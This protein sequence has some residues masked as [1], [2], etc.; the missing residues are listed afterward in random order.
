MA[1]AQRIAYLDIAKCLAIYLVCLGH[2]HPSYNG[3]IYSFHM[4]LFMMMSGF[5]S[6]H[7]LKS[8][9]L[10]FIKKKTLNLILPTLLVGLVSCVIHLFF[11]G[12]NI[13]F[14]LIEMYGCAWFLKCLFFCYLVAWVVLFC[15]KN[16]WVAVSFSCIIVFL[17][18]ICHTFNLNYFLLFFWT[19]YLFK[20]TSIFDKIGVGYMFIIPIL[21]YLGYYLTGIVRPYQTIYLATILEKPLLLPTQYIVGLTGGIFVIGLSR[22]INNI[23]RLSKLMQQ[24]GKYTLGIY[25]LQILLLERLI[26]YSFLN[27][28]SLQSDCLVNYVVLPTLALVVMSAC[29]GLIQV[30]KRSQFVNTFL[31]GGVY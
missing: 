23:N 9:F 7:S 6:E 25:V 24:V 13:K 30:L 31:F 18:P 11:R 26:E 27:Q 5:F 14:F 10:P 1:K 20:K 28:L 8:S 29:Y 4:P 12:W 15:M 22:L 17:V 16:K 19:G 3:L 2:T 21:L